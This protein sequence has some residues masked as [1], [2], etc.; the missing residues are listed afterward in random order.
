M[1]VSEFRKYTDEEIK[2]LQDVE[3]MILKDVVKILEKHNLNYYMYG[4]SLLGTIRHKGFIPWDDD[5][6]IILFREDFDKALDILNNE[7]S[8]K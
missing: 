8:D 2:H 1:R 3:L 6:D 4:G 7:L 5:I